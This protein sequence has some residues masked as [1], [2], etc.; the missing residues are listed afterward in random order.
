[1]CFNYY[2][3]MCLGSPP[4]QEGHREAKLLI[5]APGLSKKKEDVEEQGLP[6]SLEGDKES[7][8]LPT[9]L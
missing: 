6:D 9:S 1:M 5:V 7:R 8:T 4:W 3:H 2:F